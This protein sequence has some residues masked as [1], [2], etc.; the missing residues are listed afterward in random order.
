[1]GLETRKAPRLFRL[2]GV[3]AL[4]LGPGPVAGSE[5]LQQGLHAYYEQ[6]GYEYEAAARAFGRAADE[7]GLGAN[8]LDARRTLI[9]RAAM[10]PRGSLA[11]LGGYLF[12]SGH[13]GLGT[14]AA[15]AVPSL[16]VD[17][18]ASLG[19]HGPPMTSLSPITGA[20]VW[21]SHARLLM[22]VCALGGDA[23]P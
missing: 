7:V 5:A 6:Y 18:P 12:L 13:G 21:W 9:T 2:V 22:G 11:G 8:E 19:Q 23:G 1:M 10:A 4:T 15:I 16:A 14:M 20:F 3:L 17:R